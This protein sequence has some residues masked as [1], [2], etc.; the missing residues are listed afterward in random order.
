MRY[1]ALHSRAG[2]IR[3]RRMRIARRITKT[4][5]THSNTY[6]FSTTTV[7]A[8]MRLSVMLLRT[9][10]VLLLFGNMFGS[11][12][13]TFGP[14]SKLQRYGYEI[15]LIALVTATTNN[16]S[17]QQK[18]CKIETS[19][20]DMITAIVCMYFFTRVRKIVRSDYQLRNVCPC[21]R[22]LVRLPVCM[23]LF[24]SHWMIFVK[25][26]V[27][28]IFR[29]SVQKIRISLNMTRIMGTLHEDLCTFMK[30]SC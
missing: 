15:A 10:P 13:I 8:R 6:C 25:F 20:T 21:V 27:L 30:I 17:V 3:L 22:P 16:R 12:L 2:N 9:L 14:L 18:L 4:R 28:G 11:T 24:G 1:V 26:D 23:T 5:D 7:V 29:R 19:I